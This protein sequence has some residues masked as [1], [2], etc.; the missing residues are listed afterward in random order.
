[1]NDSK[2]ARDVIVAALTA[3]HEELSGEASPL[4]FDGASQILRALSE[5]GFAVVR[6]DRPQVYTELR[7]PEY[8]TGYLMDGRTIDLVKEHVSSCGRSEA[9]EVHWP[10]LKAGEGTPVVPVAGT[11]TCPGVP[12]QARA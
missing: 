1:M 10:D 9:H 11:Y 3:R 8:V 4:D 6:R 12:P 5:A 2:T 7:K